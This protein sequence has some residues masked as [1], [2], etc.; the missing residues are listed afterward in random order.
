[1]LSA[2]ISLYASTKLFMGNPCRDALQC[3]PT[4]IA[5]TIWNQADLLEASAVPH[6]NIKNIAPVIKAK[7]IIAVDANTGF[8]LYEKNSYDRRPIASIT[9]L[10]TAVI[11]LEENKLDD[12]VTISK[13]AAQ[14]AGSKIWLA[15]G[16]KITVANLLY[17]TLV[18]SANDAAYALATF[19]S[20]TAEIKDV[21]PR[22]DDSVLAS[23]RL[24]LFV[25]KMNRKADELGLK[26][27]HFTNP[28][29]LD[30][31][32]NYSS[33][34]DLAILGRYAYEKEFV[35]KAAIIRE[36][37][38]SS[39]NGKLN[40]KISTTNDLLGSYLKVFGL[41]TG[42][43]TEAGQCLIAIIESDKG[44]RIVTVIL[45]SNSRY[46]E[47]KILSDWIFRTYNWY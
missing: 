21:P 22:R 31:E 8:I 1:M 41:K 37:E 27:T 14:I 6:Y 18:H 19:N 46:S 11:I 47:T 24:G 42:T 43:T 33:A 12:V 2:L 25:K 10:M 5:H 36:T 40:H 26:D 34:Y 29:G 13:K 30:E 15:P 38:I 17:A 44:H 7:S 28:V 16:E 3:I 45:D 23:L 35:R 9:K 32:G 20:D 39:T 4:G